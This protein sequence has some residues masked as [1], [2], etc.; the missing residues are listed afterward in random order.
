MMNLASDKCFAALYRSKEPRSNTT[1][2]EERDAHGFIIPNA[3]KILSV[4]KAHTEVLYTGRCLYMIKAAGGNCSSNRGKE[5]FL[6]FQ[7][8][9][10]R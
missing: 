6:I 2:S 7:A 4:V 5:I 10:A 3:M 1:V 8:K 9:S